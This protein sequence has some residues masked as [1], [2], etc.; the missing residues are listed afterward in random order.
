MHIQHLYSFDDH[1]NGPTPP[2]SAAK[3][4][5]LLS[6]HA[7]LLIEVPLVLLVA[8]RCTWPLL[9]AVG[10]ILAVSQAEPPEGTAHLQG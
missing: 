5:S 3:L 7:L 2:L 8:G 1:V 9:P 4:H 6:F 10:S